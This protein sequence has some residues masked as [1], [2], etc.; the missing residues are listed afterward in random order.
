M[1]L[2]TA[3]GAETGRFGTAAEVG[4]R[5]QRLRGAVHSRKAQHLTCQPRTPVYRN[6]PLRHFPLRSAVHPAEQRLIPDAARVLAIGRHDHRRVINIAEHILDVGLVEQLLPRAGASVVVTQAA[7]IAQHKGIPV[8][9]DDP[10]RIRAHQAH[11]A[12]RQLPAPGR[13]AART[14]QKQERKRNK[15]SPLIHAV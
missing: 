8:K 3:R 11:N 12:V 2:F 1:G 9:T 6:Q 10:V 5:L 13:I 4:N 15:T 14:G 7:A